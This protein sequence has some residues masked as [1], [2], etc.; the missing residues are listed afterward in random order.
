MEK[1]NYILFEEF[2]HLDKLC[3][4][5]YGEQQGVTHYI[6]DMREVPER[7]YRHIPNW[8]ADLEQLVRFRHIRNYLA[9]TEGAFDKE[10]CT[11]EDIEWSQDFCQRI[12]KQSDPLALLYQYREAKQKMAQTKKSASQSQTYPLSALR[13]GI[14]QTADDIYPQED[15]DM[16]SSSFILVI[17]GLILLAFYF[18]I[19]II[20]EY[21]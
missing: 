6:D 2:K 20:I 21:T 16:Q 15:D 10:A 14:S 7:D 18:I 11:E 8:K 1:L 19:T 3:G 4:E 17:V 13:D 12:L 9:H 5:L